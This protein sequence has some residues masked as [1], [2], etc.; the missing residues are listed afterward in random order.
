MAS[1]LQES[2][3]ASLD[4]APR[5]LRAIGEPLGFVVGGLWEALPDR[6]LRCVETWPQPAC[7]AEEFEAS[8]ATS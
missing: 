8:P 6:S 4:A 5:L 7:D 2:L 1:T 3:R